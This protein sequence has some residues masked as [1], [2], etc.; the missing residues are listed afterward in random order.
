[1]SSSPGDNSTLDSLM[2]RASAA[3]VATEY[4]LAEQLCT[5]ALKRAHAHRDYESMA[6]ICLPLQ[7]AR[8]QKLQL[9]VDARAVTVFDDAGARLG[10]KH[11]GLY[12]AQPPMTGADAR[13]HRE[14]AD[15][16]KVPVVVLAREPLTRSGRWPIVAVTDGLDGRG[17]SIRVQVD[18]PAGVTPDEQSPTRDRLTAAIDVAWFIAALERL[19]DE[20]IGKLNVQDPA[21]H[22]VDDLLEFLD[23]WPYHEKL[24]QRLADACR[25]AAVDPA[26]VV[27]RR[28]GLV[29]EW[30]F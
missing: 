11:P 7:E 25:D 20:A 29:N 30:S 1:M 13:A 10:P 26:P 4:F 27:V 9:A 12:L 17:I 16:R 5:R 18:P 28:R 8:R 19:G 6:R 15:R 14:L 21:A 22:R 23:A 2:E 24:H 3:L